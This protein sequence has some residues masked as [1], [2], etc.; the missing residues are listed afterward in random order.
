MSIP[1]DRL[2]HY[3]DRV[4]E[5]IYGAS[6]LIYR[7]WP[8]GSKN[9]EDLNRLSSYSWPQ[10]ITSPAVWCHDQEPLDHAY[11][12]Q[13]LK[14]KHDSQWEE[15]CR[16]TGVRTPTIKNL[17]YNW[18]WF[19]KNLL[20]HSEQ[21]SHNLEQYRNNN[22]LIPVYYWSHA[23]IAREW[24]RYAEYVQQRKQVKKTFLI[25]NRAWSGT[26]EYRLRF[27]ELLVS[28]GLQDKCQTTVNPIEP[29]L[30][31]HYE[32]HQF[33]NP[34]W[35]PSTVLE[36]F[37]PISTA[38]SHYSADFDIEDYEATDIEV[39]LETLFDDDRLHL[40]EK[41]LRPIACAQPFILAGTHGSLEY[42]RSY[43]FKTFGDVWDESYDL[44][45]DPAER[46]IQ[47]AEL[48]KYISNWLPHQRERNM[49][50][51]QAIADYNR[52]YFFSQEFANKIINE[53][54]TNLKI[55]FEILESC[56][57]YRAWLNRW[58]QLLAF[59]EVR[60]FLKNSNTY[61]EPSESSVDLLV[62]SAQQALSQKEIQK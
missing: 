23:V 42:L 44:V 9:I 11:Y 27:A 57:N 38:P 15:I 19:E 54:K 16:R 13:H 46:L 49:A 20:L 22:K 25:Y 3:I 14:Q 24:F 35:R 60:E 62:K 51:A 18:N 41:S 17:N 50:K 21:R 43:G 36:N 30:G 58:T 31:V 59:S 4:A 8:H 2:Y 32:T 40:T 28:L 55:S 39:V 33:K 61:I 45:E 52:Q 6:V 12:S 5:D 10:T 1:L 53:L 37:F 26:R 34:I 29:E 7:F 56:D 48:M 47:I